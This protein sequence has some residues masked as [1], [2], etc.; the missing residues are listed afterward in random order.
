MT[1]VTTVNST[2]NNSINDK[3]VVNKTFNAT[4][5]YQQKTLYL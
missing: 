1:I 3:A 2:A 4:I 5:G